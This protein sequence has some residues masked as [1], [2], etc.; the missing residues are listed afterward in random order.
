MVVELQLGV[1]AAKTVIT[2]QSGV[3]T[4]NC[5]TTAYFEQD[6]GSFM[7]VCFPAQHQP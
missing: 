3:S 6:A 7:K 2:I 5:E 4:Y 1:K